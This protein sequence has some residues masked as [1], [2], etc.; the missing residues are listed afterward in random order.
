M[1]EESLENGNE[2]MSMGLNCFTDGS[3]FE[4]SAGSGFVVIAQTWDETFQTAAE[5]QHLGTLATVFQAEVNA[6]DSACAVLRALLLSG[7]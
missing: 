7:D 6:I 5:S 1:V 2:I 4:G 3:K